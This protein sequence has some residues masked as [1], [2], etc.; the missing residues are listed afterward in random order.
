MDAV[1]PFSARQPYLTGAADPSWALAPSEDQAA[2]AQLHKEL[3]AAAQPT[4]ALERVWFE[5]VVALVWERRRRAT[6]Q[7]HIV[8]RGRKAVLWR[9]LGEGSTL[10]VTQLVAAS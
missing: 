5:D 8:T 4:D 10:E 7:A 1:D 9:L 2:Y 6:L 3:L